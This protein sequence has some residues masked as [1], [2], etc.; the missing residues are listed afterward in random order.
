MADMI[1]S[2]PTPRI[3]TRGSS[4]WG[5]LLI[6]MMNQDFER[7]MIDNRSMN[8]L[9]EH[10]K[11]WVPSMSVVD[12]TGSRVILGGIRLPFFSDTSSMVRNE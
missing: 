9:V 5:T 2:H 12:F 1:F 10:N 8:V 3:S 4:M 6:V 11:G 7:S